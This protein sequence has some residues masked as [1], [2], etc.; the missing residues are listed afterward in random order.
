MYRACSSTLGNSLSTW[1]AFPGH[2]SCGIQLYGPQIAGRS[3]ARAF[4]ALA[5]AYLALAI[6]PVLCNLGNDT[7]DMGS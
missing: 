5:N 6:A 7:G 2:L 4:T 3:H 1:S